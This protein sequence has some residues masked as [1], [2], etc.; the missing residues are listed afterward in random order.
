MTGVSLMCFRTVWQQ[1][2]DCCP[3]PRDECYESQCGLQLP[4]LTIENFLLLP[5][6][7]P[8]SSKLSIT[9]RSQTGHEWQ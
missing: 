8:S 3:A 1:A 7:L 5:T 6:L 2:A 4:A 9:Q